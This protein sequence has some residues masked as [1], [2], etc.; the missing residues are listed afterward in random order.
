MSHPDDLLDG[1]EQDGGAPAVFAC[2][3]SGVETVTRAELAVAVTGL[4]AGLVGRGVGLGARVLVCSGTSLDWIVTALAAMR[5]GAVIVPVDAQ[6]DD[7]NLVH[8]IRDSLPSCVFT[9]YERRERLAGLDLAGAPD[10]F[11]L[12]SPDD[13]LHWKRLVTDRC[14]SWS[15]ANPDG[16]AVLFYT[17]GTTGAPK[18]VPLTGANLAFQIDTVRRSRIATERD[19]LLLALP[20]HHVYPFVIGLLAPL[21]V[22]APVVLPQALTGPRLLG[23]IK[24][25]R[26]SVMIGVP[27]LYRALYE[28]IHAGV[29]S[30]GRTAA[31]VLDGAEAFSNLL[32]RRLGISA[33]RWILKGLHNHIGPSLR[34]MASGGSLL[35]P[36][37]GRRLECMG[38]R[39]AVGYGLTETSPLLTLRL[40]GTGP[41]ESVGR[42]VSGVELRIDFAGPPDSDEKEA[43]SRPSGSDG[44]GEILARGPGVFHGYRN[45][46]GET[47]R[48]FT[49]DGW[50]RT[51]DLGR[52]DGKGYLYVGGRVSTM[53]VTESGEN[54]QPD[55]VERAYEEHPLISEIGVLSKN[56]RLVGLA[57]PDVEALRAE[58]ED[59]G[60]AAVRSALQER[61]R[62]MAS[63]M[64][65]SEVRITREALP[66]TRLGKI[67]RHLLV[68]RYDMAESGRSRTNG[69]PV[70]YDDMSD[71]DRALLENAT[72]RRVWEWLC[73]RFPDKSLSPDTSP[74]MDLGVDSMEWLNLTLEIREHAGVEISEEAIARIASVR[75]LL[76][77]AADA[78]SKPG[79][80]ADP[81]EAP[82]SVL[83]AYQQRWLK[84]LGPLMGALGLG[85]YCLGSILLRLLYRI[86]T[87][88]RQ[89]LPARGP[90]VIAPNHAS[91]LDPLV[92]GHVLGARGMPHTYWAGLTAAAFNTAA[93]RFGCRLGRAVPVNPEQGA[94]GGLA[95]AS[96]ILKGRLRLVWFPEGQRSLDGELQEFKPGLGKVLD[97]MPVPVIPVRLAGTW[98]AWPVHRAWPR[99]GRLTVTFGEPVSVDELKSECEEGEPEQRIVNGLKARIAALGSRGTGRAARWR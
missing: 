28:G 41:L 20:L 1:L 22:R 99:P 65:L 47:R 70:S 86:Q 46:E 21:A 11:L 23:A 67:R 94:A 66:R 61:S 35:D 14:G 60:E 2:G 68:A 80:A 49:A 93:K 91:Y 12:D 3:E 55:D 32:R 29:A 42:P 17:S 62:E 73:E 59:A 33:G 88:G 90:C 25:C 37:L 7:E 34:V 72:A 9:D 98:E 89:N 69:E 77:E 48:A 16:D 31:R 92:L 75:D 24:D 6:M 15:A 76:R 78:S 27:R 18:G 53:I 36:E 74:G 58:G 81:V 19:R 57:V 13:D 64:R 83:T 95:F 52:F 26:A 50:F 44:W 30:K 87:V 45:L 97:R 5:A 85:A 4:A 56:R 43:G 71:H 84:P 51:G 10:L 38:W 82:Y 63:Y 54:V 39:V 8:V 79:P 96:A 40:P